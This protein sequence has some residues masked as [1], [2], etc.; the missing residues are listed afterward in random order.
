[1][2]SLPKLVLAHELNVQIFLNVSGKILALTEY[3]LRASLDIWKAATYYN[4]STEETNLGYFWGLNLLQ[5]IEQLGERVF[6]CKAQTSII[7]R[8]MDILE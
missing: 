1:M 4:H 3:Y 7:E 2:H 8:D 6:A 5:P